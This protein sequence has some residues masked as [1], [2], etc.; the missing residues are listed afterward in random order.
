MAKKV[1]CPNVNHPAFR[2]LN[3]RLGGNV[4]LSYYIWNKTKGEISDNGLPYLDEYMKLEEDVKS[5]L[6]NGL[7]D[8]EYEAAILN[9]ENAKDVSFKYGTDSKTKKKDYSFRITASDGSVL[10]LTEKRAAID[11]MTYEV[12]QALIVHDTVKVLD[13][14]SSAKGK[15]SRYRLSVIKEYNDIVRKSDRSGDDILKAKRLKAQYVSL[16]KILDEEAWEKLQEAAKVK[17]ELNGIRFRSKNKKRLRILEDA[18]VE[19]NPEDISTS[20]T[21]EGDITEKTFDADDSLGRDPKDYSTAAVKAIMMGIQ[22]PGSNNLG[23]FALHD[24]SY[25]YKQILMVLTT[26]NDY[27]RNGI[28]ESLKKEAEKHPMDNIFQAVYDILESGDEQ[29]RI[30]F[31]V[32]MNKIRNEFIEVRFNERDPSR[33]RVSNAN[34]GRVGNVVKRQWSSDMTNHLSVLSARYNE[35]PLTLLTKIRSI[36]ENFFDTVREELNGKGLS[37]T[38]KYEIIKEQSYIMLSELGIELSDDAFSDLMDGSSKDVYTTSNEWNLASKNFDNSYRSDGVFGSIANI[39]KKFN[40]ATPDDVSLTSQMVADALVEDLNQTGLRLLA[41]VEGK[42]SKRWFQNSFP[43]KKSGT[44]NGL[45]YNYRQPSPNASFIRKLLSHVDPKFKSDLAKSIGLRKLSL[46]K[47]SQ[48]GGSVNQNGVVANASEE[49]EDAFLYETNYA[50][51]SFSG[52]DTRTRNELNIVDLVYNAL[53][54]FQAGGE[55]YM[56]ILDTTKSDKKESPIYRVKRKGFITG[57]IDETTGRPITSFIKFENGRIQID[58]AA[59]STIMN[60][61]MMA[62]CMG[63]VEAEIDRMLFVLSDPDES[64]PG[65]YTD[66]INELKRIFGKNYIFNAQFFYS[67]PALNSLV[68]RDKTGAIDPKGLKGLTNTAK[69]RD[70]LYEHFVNQITEDISSWKELGLVKDSGGKMYTN[71]IQYEYGKSKFYKPFTSKKVAAS[72]ADL[73]APA[74][75]AEVEGSGKKVKRLNDADYEYLANALSLDATAI[76]TVGAVYFLDDFKALNIN[77]NE[78]RGIITKIKKEANNA[79]FN[80]E[81]LRM[82]AILSLESNMNTFSVMGSFG[83]TISGDPATLQRSM[84]STIEKT[85]KTLK[86]L[87]IPDVGGND[88]IEYAVGIFMNEYQKRLSSDIAPA[89]DAVPTYTI[90]LPTGGRVVGSRSYDVAFVG[91]SFTDPHRYIASLPDS[92]KEKVDKKLLERFTGDGTDGLEY[93]SFYAK[94]ESL[95]RTGKVGAVDFL[96]MREHYQKYHKVDDKFLGHFVLGMGKPRQINSVVKD[97]ITGETI[98]TKIFIKSAELPLLAQF[99][100]SLNRDLDNL[101]IAM[102]DGFTTDP[103]KTDTHISRVVHAK[104]VKLGL[105]SPSSIYGKDSTIIN[106]KDPKK[107]RAQ[108]DESKESLLWENFGY[109]QETPTHFGEDRLTNVV[110][111]DKSILGGLY[112][113]EFN[114]KSSQFGGPISGRKLD[115]IKHRINKELS[116]RAQI[117]IDDKFRP[118]GEFDV[119]T[120]VDRAIR[121]DS[122]ITNNEASSFLAADRYKLPMMWSPARKVVEEFLFSTYS[123]AIRLQRPGRANPQSPITGGGQIIVKSGTPKEF[124]SVTFLDGRSPHKPLQY[125]EIVTNENGKLELKTIAEIIVPFDFTVNGKSVKITDVD[126]TKIDKGLL[127]I[128]GMRLPNQLHQSQVLFKIVGFTPAEMGTVCIVPQDIVTQTGSDFDIDKLY[129]YWRNAFILKDGRMVGTPSNI[130]TYADNGIEINDKELNDFINNNFADKFKPSREEVITKA[131]E[132]DYIQ[133]FEA[134]LSNP[135]VVQKSLEPLDAPDLKITG[136]KYFI[137]KKKAPWYSIQRQVSEY[138]SQQSANSGINIYAKLMSSVILADKKGITFKDKSISKLRSPEKSTPL[139]LNVINP[140]GVSMIHGE[141]RTATRNVVILLSESI[142]NAKN[143][144]LI[145]NGLNDTTFNIAATLMILADESGEA[146]SLE[147][148][149]ALLNQEVVK[150]S[151]E[152]MSNSSGII[153]GSKNRLDFDRVKEDAIVQMANRYGVSIEALNAKLKELKKASYNEEELFE[154]YQTGQKMAGKAVVSD[155]DKALYLAQQYDIINNIISPLSAM[156]KEVF[157]LN[158]NTSFDKGFHPS[159]AAN[160]RLLNKIKDDN[161]KIGL[162]NSDLYTMIEAEEG[163]AESSEVNT[164]GQN[165]IMAKNITDAIS[166]VLGYNDSRIKG[167]VDRITAFGS[168]NSN[169]YGA[170]VSSIVDNYKS[171]VFTKVVQ[172]SDSSRGFGLNISI[173]YLG[174]SLARNIRRLQRNPDYKNNKFIRSVYISKDNSSVSFNS[175]LIRSSDLEDSMEGFY[176]LAKS[177]NQDTQKIAQSIIIYELLTNG[178]KSRTSFMKVIP[179]EIL[180]GIGFYNKLANQIQNINNSPNTVDEFVNLFY[181]NNPSFMHAMDSFSGQSKKFVNLSDN[182]DEASGKHYV[183]M[184]PGFKLSDFPLAIKSAAKSK[185]NYYYIYDSYARDGVDGTYN[186]YYKRYDASVLLGSAGIIENN[187]IKTKKRSFDTGYFTSYSSDKISSQYFFGGMNNVEDFSEDFMIEKTYFMNALSDQGDVKSLIPIIEQIGS[188]YSNWITSL[189]KALPD[190]IGN[191]PVLHTM[192]RSEDGTIAE[193]KIING[194]SMIV[195]HTDD[196]SNMIDQTGSVNFAKETLLHEVVHAMMVESYKLGK[197]GDPKFTQISKNIDIIYKE[198]SNALKT[199]SIVNPVTGEEFMHDEKPLVYG[200]F[201]KNGKISY[202]LNNG[203]TTH[204]AMEIAQELWPSEESFEEWS[205][206]SRA[207]YLFNNEMDFMSEALSR[208]H[209]QNLLNDTMLSDKA[210]ESIGGDASK[211]ILRSIFDKFIILFNSISEFFN[212]GVN[213]K[214]VLE[215]VMMQNLAITNELM[216]SKPVNRKITK[217]VSEKYA[218]AQEQVTSVPIEG[219]VREMLH[220]FSSTE[221]K[222]FRYLLNNNAFKTKCE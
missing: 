109:Q 80:D 127:N 3:D 216:I 144:N 28:M 4:N 176:A 93:V 148:V 175:E 20:D 210:Y 79:K 25:V 14:F 208:G 137:A 6:L 136:E 132:N 85:R 56:R 211:S 37:K 190:V 149:P 192:E 195:I 197:N 46:F 183:S 27:S 193:F 164:T 48:L 150:I 125:T 171:F 59:K 42:S 189:I 19:G 97:L 81:M 39:L 30:Q 180:E 102:E 161:S 181:R 116:R 1:V 95:F 209:I 159:V 131:L 157:K 53:Q 35:E 203:N 140:Y 179:T 10:S 32:A 107:L 101:R 91:D 108:L 156:A 145:P 128:I 207:L 73:D 206:F 162:E 71:L 191:I 18:G 166:D 24:Q 138:K 201:V 199:T 12:T 65:V 11:S 194:K 41:N 5:L 45:R 98:V 112:D 36:G 104:A 219:T 43:G 186:L 135:E 52:G 130:I 99:T 106:G 50:L 141:D 184:S 185:Y 212:G 218:P 172:D 143:G 123:D 89:V 119:P 110:Q 202:K 118:E 60:S 147:Y 113:T 83:M 214:S 9:I 111:A 100:Q 2:K 82:L 129:Q 153:G 174:K 88:S 55:K 122:G 220:N 151:S 200:Q 163:S 49:F 74:E 215:A 15:L 170:I 84:E 155:D 168:Y 167:I 7:D 103:S 198:T 21:E 26:S 105:Q 213:S 152:I 169:D 188:T 126:L 96:E 90:D 146:L 173:A 54:L 165:L 94:L 117:E 67:I 23:V 69:F 57:I 87:N 38:E 78:A 31:E 47:S 16:S 205:E 8:S 154:I 61:D 22:D 58:T 29:I 115:L 124:G 114:F 178:S 134:V 86:G 182:V 204:S 17:L 66:K 70:A 217:K 51:K 221:R 68:K 222:T 187:F 75:D 62:D 72:E 76:K 177:S 40:V 120:V 13:I 92:Y 158:N 160:E 77:T 139:L 133:I 44:S 121:V 33:S 142:D 196:F 63:V 64:N 34:N